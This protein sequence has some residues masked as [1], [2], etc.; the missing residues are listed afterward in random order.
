MSAW[1]WLTASPTHAWSAV[2]VTAFVFT[3]SG[4][5]YLG[6]TEGKR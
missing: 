6:V 5:T 4:F 1:Q 2:I 3:V